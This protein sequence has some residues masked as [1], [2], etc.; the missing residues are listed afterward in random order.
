MSAKAVAQGRLAAALELVKFSHTI[1]ALP[2][3][4]LS[5]F[6]A[7]GGA[8]A[9][10]TTLLVLAAMVG[11]RTGAMA[12][13]RI[14]DLRFDRDNARTRNRP[15]VTGSITLRQAWGLVLAGFTVLVAAAAGLNRLALMLSPLAIVILCSYSFTKRFTWLSHLVLGL[16][17]AGAPLGAWI[18]VTGGVALPPFLLAVAVIAWVAGFDV[19]YACQDLDHDRRVGLHSIP[20]RFGLVGAL[21]ISTALHVVTVLVLLAL[22]FV[23]PLGPLFLAGVGIAGALLLY[24]HQLVT[25]KSL[26]RL[27]EAFFT[28][29]GLVS[30]ALFVFGALDLTLFHA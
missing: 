7:A 28:M 4:L 23:T 14:V 9:L 30:V 2:F 25:P 5:A 26:A 20:A 24:E 15:L 16:A 29:N 21:R 3:A 6:V 1:F 18:A 27:D 17:L 19:L 8:P 12:F 22:P 13:N 11:A 10:R